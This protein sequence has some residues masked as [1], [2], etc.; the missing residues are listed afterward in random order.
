MTDDLVRRIADARFSG[1][2]L[3]EGYDVAEVDAFLDRLAGAV[4]A[5]GE[6]RAARA[7]A[8][9]DDARFRVVRFREGYDIAEVDGFLDEMRA[10]VTGRRARAS[11]G[12][13]AEGAGPPPAAH[14]PA[15]AAPS[16]LERDTTFLGWLFGRR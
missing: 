1:T 11:S 16:D 12:A 8:L 4:R 14:G 13:S 7:A 2:R 6:H 9:V 3:R 5:E 10:A 15:T